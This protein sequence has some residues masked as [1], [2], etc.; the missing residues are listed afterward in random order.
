MRRKL[1]SKKAWKQKVRKR[2]NN[3]VKINHNRDR[4]RPSDGLNL[5][6]LKNSVI[7]MQLELAKV[8]RQQDP[9]AVTRMVNKITKSKIAQEWAVY[10][11]ISSTG[12]RSPG[13][14]EKERP[15]TQSAYD[16]LRKQLWKIVSKPK[17]YKSSPFKRVWFPKPNSNDLRPIY[18]PT[19]IDRALQHLY[20]ITLDVFQEEQT[21]NL[22]EDNYGFRAFRSPGWA[23]KAITLYSWKVKPKY[24]IELDIRKCYDK[25]SH[26]FIENNIAKQSINNKVIEI[27]PNQIINQWLKSGYIDIKGTI[28]PKDQ[29]I[30]TEVGIPQGGPISPTIANMTLNG[31]GNAA[32]IEET[33]PKSRIW[34]KPEDEIS[35]RLHG[36][37][38]FL[39]KGYDEKNAQQ[40]KDELIKRSP[41][42]LPKNL[43]LSILRRRKIQKQGNWS[44]KLKSQN[45]EIEKHDQLRNEWK[46]K[47]I[48]FADDCTIFVGDPKYYNVII[49]QINKFLETRGLEINKEKTKFKNLNQ[50]DKLSFVGFE[51]SYLIKNG[52][53]K[54]YNYP[55]AQKIKNVKRKIVELLKRHKYTP[56]SAYYTI[57][58]VLRGW[59]A[60]YSSG[61]SKK[62]FQTLSNW[63]WHKMYKY[64]QIY[65]KNKPEYKT[66]SQSHK[67]KRISHQIYT[68]CRS[69]HPESGSG[70]L[71]WSVP[72]KLNPKT[73]YI[74]DS[75]PYML[76]SP[77]RTKVSTSSII[78]G[79]NAYFPTE[80]ETLLKKALYWKRG[81]IQTIMKKNNGKCECC[82]VSLLDGT[83]KMEIHHKWPIALGGSNKLKNICVLCSECHKDISIAVNKR[84]IDKIKE[85][86]FRD[87]LTN[88][89]N[90]IK[91][92]DN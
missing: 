53:Y 9:D 75:K 68:Y 46:T 67:L 5:S 45:T 4:F 43:V 47:L 83:T 92:T 57:N 59:C 76:Y 84:D 50:G 65:Y 63:L 31:I 38:I 49:D 55:P 21:K 91:N 80:R 69:P 11:T 1:K 29:I 88:I 10:R 40:I 27:I 6:E 66:K 19:Y 20:L 28:T 37:E 44:I 78:T 82:D 54:L 39:S 42:P 7:K 26:K 70:A 33:K 77:G 81:L 51:F 17:R 86:E 90:N 22:D 52:K 61:N 13:I 3:N 16:N 41:E 18:V 25:I 32:K 89:S 71:W 36:K 8:I 24:V 14:K 64:W 85:F 62:I 23:A 60:Y 74:R 79:Q 15:T 73:R 35:W 56:Y 48:R 12:A 2:K 30:P 87:L 72:H 58:A 34:I